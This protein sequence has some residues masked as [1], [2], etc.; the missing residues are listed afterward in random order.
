MGQI[1]K[2]QSGQKNIVLGKVLKTGLD[3]F[4]LSDD[5]FDKLSSSAFTSV[6]TDLGPA[7]LAS[8][9]I[10]LSGVTEANDTLVTFNPSFEGTLRAVAALVTTAATTPAKSAEIKVFIDYDGG[11]SQVNT[12]TITGTPTGGNFTITVNGVTSGT[13]AYNAAAA[14]VQSTLEAMSN[15]ATGD[16][17]VSGSAG[18]PYTLTWGGSYAGVA[19]TVSSSG[20]GLTGGTTP[21]ATTT[22][23]TPAVPGTSSPVA[24]QGAVINLTS[25]NCTPAGAVVPGTNITKSAAAPALFK[26][27]SRITIR[28][29]VAPTAFAEGAVAFLL[30]C[31]PAPAA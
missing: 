18:G 16:V 15:I 23:P 12:V 13:I 4:V 6:L 20:A 14:T 31:D 26:N 7:V 29:G 2:V 11:T 24:V 10:T 21:A 19:V 30:F 17:T 25:A 8:A 5:Q 27:G 28:S 3:Q 1:V 9:P 22:T